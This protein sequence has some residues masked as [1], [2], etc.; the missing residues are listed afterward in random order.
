LKFL[1]QLGFMLPLFE[2]MLLKWHPEILQFGPLQK[3]HWDSLG[4]PKGPGM[5]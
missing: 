3:H 5:A 2:T 4:W 1:K